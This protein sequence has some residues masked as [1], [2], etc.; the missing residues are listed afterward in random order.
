MNAQGIWL[1]VGT[2][3]ALL[4]ITIVLANKDKSKQTRLTFL[5]IANAIYLG[6]VY[7][8]YNGMLQK[9]ILMF[10]GIIALLDFLA[11]KNIYYPHPVNVDE[12]RHKLWHDDPKNWKLGIFYFNPEDKRIF[13][14]KRMEGLG[15]TINFANS[16]SVLAMTA[17][18]VLICIVI[19]VLQ[20]F[21]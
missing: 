21:K 19:N 15:W 18:I 14:P 8:Y 3:I 11:L 16:D 10:L 20:V 13:P 6:S 12:E 1:I 7:Y 4:L 5:S 9:D 17:I 2:F